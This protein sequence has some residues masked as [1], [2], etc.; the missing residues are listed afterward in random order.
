MEIM[1]RFWKILDVGMIR[2]QEKKCE[3]RSSAISYTWKEGDNID[4]A[5]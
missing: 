5:F 4:E 2:F 1:E 3:F